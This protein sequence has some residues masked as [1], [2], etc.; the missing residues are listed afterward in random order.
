MKIVPM[1]AT[2]QSAP[3]PTSSS[4]DAARA[5]AIA[6][7]SGQGQSEQP[8]VQ[9]QNAIAPEEMGAL[10]IPKPNKHA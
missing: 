1:G 8:A 10:S 6:M 4:S 9:N 5:R 2:P 7:V 3:T